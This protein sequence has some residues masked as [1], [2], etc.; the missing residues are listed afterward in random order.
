ML[1]RTALVIA[2]LVLVGSAAAC[3]GGGDSADLDAPR[4]PA[5]VALGESVYQAECAGCHGAELQ[6]GVGPALEDSTRGMSDDTVRQR[7]VN[8]LGA[9]PAFGERLSEEE[10]TGVIDFLR[11]RQQA[12]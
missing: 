10:I 4:D 9:M 11:S 7:I 5:S 12:E 2:S 1:R 8:G 3:G 6:G